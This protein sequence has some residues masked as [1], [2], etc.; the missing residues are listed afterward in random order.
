ME[1]VVEKN[2]RNVLEWLH[3]LTIDISNL[4]LKI[5]IGEPYDEEL[6]KKFYLLYDFWVNLKKEE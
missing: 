3:Q 5:E 6:A 4:R 2:E 1:Q